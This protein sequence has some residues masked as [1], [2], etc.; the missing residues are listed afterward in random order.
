MADQS[1]PV[2]ARPEAFEAVPEHFPPY[3]Y[4]DRKGTPIGFESF[5]HL[6][7]TIK[8][9]PSQGIGFVWTPKH[10]Y[11]VTPEEVPELFLAVKRFRIEASRDNYLDA[12]RNAILF[13]LFACYAVFTLY[14]G[15]VIGLIKNQVFSYG[16]ALLIM[17]GLM[18]LYDAWKSRRAASQLTP[19]AMAADAPAVRFEIW[20]GRQSAAG[21]QRLLVGMVIV[22]LAQLYDVFVQKQGVAAIV[23]GRG[24]LAEGGLFKPF[25]GD[26]VSFLTAPFVHGGPLHFAFNF[27]ALRYLGKRVEVLASWQHLMG[28]FFVTMLAGGFCSLLLVDSPTVGASGAICGLL[29]FLMVFETTHKALVPRSS[30]RR[31]AG[32]VFGLVLIGL[33]GFSFID[34]AAHAGGLFAG[35]GYAWVVFPKSSSPL[36][37]HPG[38]GAGFW[39]M[40][41]LGLLIFSVVVAAL[42]IAG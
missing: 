36:R 11:L 31:L 33:V 40:A 39:G 19:D 25:N 15:S 42:R 23:D 29:G 34:N 6:F 5:D 21:T 22:G 8:D 35:M 26:Y 14:E 28:C 2:W 4:L 16:L 18:P 24:W 10:P 7:Q 41:S 37:P 1:L 30:R 32:A 27:L 9:D 20:L 12:R 17:M 38:S 3:G 13:G